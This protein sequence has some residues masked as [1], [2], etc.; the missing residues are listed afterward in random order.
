MLPKSK[1]YKKF[2]KCI[3][4]LTLY[5]LDFLDHFRPCLKQDAAT[6]MGAFDSRQGFEVLRRDFLSAFSVRAIIHYR[7]H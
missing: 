4:S 5:G 7:T 3:C 6:T 2:Q 1:N